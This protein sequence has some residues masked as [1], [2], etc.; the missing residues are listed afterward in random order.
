MHRRNTHT[1]SNQLV[2]AEKL[3]LYDQST[4][5]WTHAW[6]CPDASKLQ[7]GIPLY[8]YIMEVDILWRYWQTIQI[9]FDCVRLCLIVLLFTL[10]KAK[11]QINSY[12][13]TVEI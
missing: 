7:S 6:W 13:V 5:S 8:Q 2:R 12:V 11:A 9:V 3:N 10:C 1:C 4:D